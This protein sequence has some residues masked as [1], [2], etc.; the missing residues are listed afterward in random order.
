MV[1]FIAGFE[2]LGAVGV[3]GLLFWATGRRRQ[4]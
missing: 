3:I 2:L 1:G 4:R